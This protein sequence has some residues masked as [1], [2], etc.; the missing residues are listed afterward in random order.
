MPTFLIV[1]ATGKQGGKAISTLLDHQAKNKDL[2]LRF[3]TRNPD[4]ASAKKLVDQGAQAFKADL[5]DRESLRQALTGVDRAFLV[6]DAMAGEE[7]EAQQGKTFVDVAKEVGVKHIVFTSV[8]AADTAVSVPHFRS[9]YQV[10]DLTLPLAQTDVQVEKHLVASG[11]TYTILRPVAFMVGGHAPQSGSHAY[12]TGQ[13]P[14]RS[15]YCPIHGH[16]HVLCCRRQQA[17]RL[18]RYGRYRCFRQ[19]SPPQTR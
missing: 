7:K 10:S 3:I 11:L 15:R 9:K 18:Y 13:F 12:E 5:F 16:R 17:R 19:P 8:S 2:S 4:S 1:G 6:T 14:R